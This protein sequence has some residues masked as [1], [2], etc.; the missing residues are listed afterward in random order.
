MSLSKEKKEKRNF[1]LIIQA[2][3][4]RGRVNIESLAREYQGWIVSF[5]A[6][7]A[8]IIINSMDIRATNERG[9]SIKF[10][11]TLRDKYLRERK[12]LFWDARIYDCYKDLIKAIGHNS[13]Y[14]LF[15][16]L[17]YNV[18]FER[19]A[20]YKAPYFSIM[21]KDTVFKITKIPPEILVKTGYVLR[22]N[23][24]VING[25][26]R[27]LN[28]RRVNTIIPQDIAVPEPADRLF[29]SSII[30]FY[31]GTLP[32]DSSGNLYLP[33]K[34]GQLSIVDGQ[35][36]IY[37]IAAAT[38]RGHFE[39]PCAIMENN[40]NRAQQTQLFVS[41][42]KKATR[43]PANLLLDLDGDG[44]LTKLTKRL[45]ESKLFNKIINFNEL[46]EQ[47]ESISAATFINGGGLK[48]ILNEKL[49]HGS[50]VRTGYL[51]TLTHDDFD[52]YYALLSNYFDLWKRAF[53]KHW[54]KPQKYI[55]ASNRGMRIIFRF[56]KPLVE[57]YGNPRNNRARKSILAL[58]RYLKRQMKETNLEKNADIKRRYLGEGGATDLFND[59]VS[60]T[61][62]KD[63]DFEC[64]AH[65]F[66]DTVDLQW[67]EGKEKFKT[68][69]A[70]AHKS[71]LIADGFFDRNALNNISTNFKC[72]NIKILMTDEH[73]ITDLRHEYNDV[74]RELEGK[75]IKIEIR[76]LNKN[77]Y[78]P[79]FFSLILDEKLDYTGDV[80]LNMLRKRRITRLNLKTPAVAQRD[81]SDFN[82]RWNTATKIENY[83]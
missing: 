72:K 82:A 58:L 35:H 8:L 80:R 21:Q 52:S 78:D 38:S 70:R 6:D 53:N 83:S 37:G 60:L 42:N 74:K 39:L 69:L 41:V 75:G 32:V 34:Y 43:P 18:N 5:R 76:I 68:I 17:K 23:L 59:F 13:T 71:I 77:S 26:Q 4:R 73:S 20:F 28:K 1:K 48:S 40:L 67:T 14:Q 62:G 63:F 81:I 36:R 11:D 19:R 29:P 2:R 64:K 44:M 57:H 50:R 55:I 79:H 31:D 16:D 61:G 22:R 7:R 30:C 54:G 56:F 45:D 12:V 24:N 49:E 47:K 51:T 3:D 33:L 66:E 65:P 27:L 25:F 10:D 15:S 46:E 9:R